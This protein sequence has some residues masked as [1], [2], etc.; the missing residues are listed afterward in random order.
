MEHAQPPSVLAKILLSIAVATLGIAFAVARPRGDPDY[1]M[2]D[3]LMATGLA[4]HE[5][6]DM[7]V[8]GYVQ[9]GSIREVND[10]SHLFT[11]QFHGVSLRVSVSGVLPDTFKDQSE[12]VVRGR[13]E[14]RDDGWTLDGTELLAKCATKY[15][16]SQRN[17]NAK[18]E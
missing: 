9:A 12:L 6:R 10:G 3:G 15:D 18:F 8:H 16:G 13:L 14:K 4:A 11:L 5:G 2:V 7:R 17:L 1:F